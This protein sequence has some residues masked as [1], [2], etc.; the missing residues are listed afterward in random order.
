MHTD[1]DS[2][3]HLYF[4][5]SFLLPIL[6]GVVAVLT[7]HL[8][9][10]CLEGVYRRLVVATGWLNISGEGILIEVIVIGVIVLVQVG[11]IDRRGCETMD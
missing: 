4:L 6:P 10:V 8:K 5:G 11:L 2:L 9:A 3:C 7:H 1:F